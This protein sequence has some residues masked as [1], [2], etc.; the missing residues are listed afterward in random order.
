MLVDTPLKEN[1]IVSIKTIYAEEIVAKFITE[2]DKQVTISKPLSIMATQTGLGLGPFAFSVPAD[3]KVKVNKTA[4]AW[5]SK[6][7]KDIANQY[8]STTTGIQIA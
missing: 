8:I 2:D 5:M 3:S 4:I 1:D 7:D 6:T